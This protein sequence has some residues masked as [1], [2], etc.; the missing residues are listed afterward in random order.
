[1]VQLYSVVP[2][3]GWD[4]GLL[5]N[6]YVK[7]VALRHTGEAPVIASD[8]V[9]VSLIVSVTFVAGLWQRRPVI[10]LSTTQKS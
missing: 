9:K 8:N 7:L 5:G 1:M 4:A 10:A 2:P 6:E 3:I